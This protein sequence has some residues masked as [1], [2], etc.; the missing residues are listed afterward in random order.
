MRKR[1]TRQ[2]IIEDLGFNYIERQ[3]LLAGYTLTQ[4]SKD[5]GYDFLMTT[6]NGNGEVDN[7]LI[8]GQ[9]KSTDHIKITQKGIQFSLSKRD[10]EL[11]LLE[12]SLMILVLYDAQKE[13]AYYLI[14][15]DYFKANKLLLQN[16][17]KFIQVNITLEKIFDSKSIKQLRYIKEGKHE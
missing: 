1:R 12:S 7:G 9:L 11:W 5:Y 3:V 6:Y 15:K 2:H 17:N 13:K 14:L 4:V 10:L 16:I 8:F